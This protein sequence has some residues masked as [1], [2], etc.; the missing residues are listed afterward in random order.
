[1][2]LTERLSIDAY[3]IDALMP[4]LV[5]HDRR[6]SAFVVYLFLWRRTRGGSRAAVVSHQQMASATGLVRRSVQQAFRL[7][8]RRRLIE[9]SR[10]SATAAASVRLVCHWRS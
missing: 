9:V 2:K 5:G 6:A 3:V 10:A 8:A 7:L 4:D 1:M